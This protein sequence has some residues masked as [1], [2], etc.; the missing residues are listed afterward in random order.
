[1]RPPDD[2]HTRA[3]VHVAT[4]AAE[5]EP[6]T[7]SMALH[8]AGLALACVVAVLLWLRSDRQHG[9]PAHVARTEMHAPERSAG[10]ATPQ[11]AMSPQLLMTPD[12]TIPNREPLAGLPG[13]RERFGGTFAIRHPAYLPADIVPF[14]VNW[15]PD[16]DPRLRDL[17]RGELLTW[18]YSA[19]HGAVLVLA[20]GTGV[21][22]RPLTGGADRAGRL[23]LADGTEVIWT[24]GHP[25]RQGGGADDP[26]WEGAELTLGVARSDGD[27][28]YL[29]SPIIS[30]A[31]LIR[32]AES[33]K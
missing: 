15:Q 22:V 5:S 23:R 2:D 18:F 20:Q 14:T 31:E 7:P 24:V 26:A 33:L 28:W 8:L 4:D 25:G 1:M 21:G 9:R 30:L 13:A 6:F 27:G 3:G 11:G 12:P 29:R 10:A 19:E 16:S 32:V 17:G